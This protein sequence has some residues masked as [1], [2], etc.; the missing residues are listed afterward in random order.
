MKIYDPALSGTTSL[1]SITAGTTETN[2]VVVA[3]DGSLKYR[4]DLSL[5]GTAGT[6]GA[7]GTAGTNG[8]QGAQGT[9]GTNGT[10]GT[11]GTNGTQ[12]TAGT[13]GTQGTAGT[14]GTQGTAGTNGTQGSAGTNGTQGTVG[15]TGPQGTTG[16]TGTFNSG[17][18]AG[19]VTYLPN[20]TDGTAYQALWGAAYT[21]G[22]GTIAYSCAGVTIT[23][24]TGLLTCS[25]LTE[26]SSKRYKE[27][28]IPLED[29]L[30]KIIKL[31]GVKYNKIGNNFQEIGVIAEEV[32]KIIPEIVVYN[33]DNQPDSVSYGRITA[34][35]IEAIKELKAEIDIL[36]QK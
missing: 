7:Q 33:E 3:G 16:A 18:N 6:T 23:S 29:S 36:K 19:S 31:R 15:T 10:Q 12:G 2:I 13:N 30:D 17:T 8:T 35:L 5:Q 24:S 21:N 28:L 34:V 11:A 4:T 25:S 32:E 9:A 1:P 26:S 22:T 14:N 27:N 20:R